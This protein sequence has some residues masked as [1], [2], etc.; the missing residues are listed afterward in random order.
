M[1]DDHNLDWEAI[2]NLLQALCSK[3][4]M[5]EEENHQ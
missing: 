1:Y 2:N 3:I 5:V 4:E